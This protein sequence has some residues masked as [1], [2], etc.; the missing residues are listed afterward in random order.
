MCGEK[1]SPTANA[2]GRAGSPP[3]VRGKA[4]S[5]ASPR[6]A[7]GITPACAGKS[8]CAA[9]ARGGLK[10]H[11]RV[12]GEKSRHRRRQACIRGSP[13]RVRGK[14]QQLSTA[15]TWLRITPACAGKRT[16][17]QLY[18]I[19]RKDHPRVCGEKRQQLKKGDWEK[20][21]PPRVRGKA[22]FKVWIFRPIWDHPR[23]CG[24]KSIVLKFNNVKM[25]SPPR[26]RGKD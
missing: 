17:L 18:A 16:W 13:P 24:E 9:S 10:D 1:N 22:A 25:G 26:V 2:A 19:A 4:I 11:P 12:C 6:R 15:C 20:G 7:V 23:V 8:A 14:A 5:G 21:S 3:R